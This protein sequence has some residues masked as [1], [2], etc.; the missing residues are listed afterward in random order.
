MKVFIVVIITLLKSLIVNNRL[1]KMAFLSDRA[2]RGLQ[3][4]KYKPAGYTILDDLHQPVWNCAY[5]CRIISFYAVAS[6]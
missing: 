4:Y 1:A 6:P 2:L 3:N 5:L